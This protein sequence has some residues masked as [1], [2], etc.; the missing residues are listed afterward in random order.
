MM[1]DDYFG[2][3]VEQTDISRSRKPKNQ[4][5]QLLHQLNAT[6]FRWHVHNDDN[7]N[8]DGKELRDEYLSIRGMHEIEDIWIDAP[9]SF[10]ELL[11]GLS[12]RLYFNADYGIAGEWFWKMLENL[13]L[14]HF[15]DVQYNS[16]KFFVESEVEEA[17]ERVNERS[18]SYEGRGG[19]FPL[20]KPSRDQRRVELWYQLSAYLLEGANA[21]SVMR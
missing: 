18:Y 2:W 9:A 1:N 13:D 17:L 16:D 19:L 15:N 12:R 20:R 3:L 21:D 11:I 4:Y 14:Q 10:L 6:P 8:E 7:R 5:W